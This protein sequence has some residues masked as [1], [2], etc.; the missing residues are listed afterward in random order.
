MA[1]FDINSE[2]FIVHVAIW[3]RE[4]MVVDSSRKAQIKTQS[5]ALVRAPLF[6]K[7]LTKVPV[8]YYDYSDVFLVENVAEIL[9]NTE[10]NEHTIKL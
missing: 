2:T 10:M 7:A 3:E 6:D 4:E 1:A 8:E 5:G 9:E